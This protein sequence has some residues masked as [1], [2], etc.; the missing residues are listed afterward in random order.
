MEEFQIRIEKEN[1]L[2]ARPAGKLVNVAGGFDSNITVTK[3]NQSASA[4]GL[5]ALMGLGIKQGDKVTVNCEGVDE[6]DAILAVKEFFENNFLSCKNNNK[7]INDDSESDNEINNDVRKE[8]T[9]QT[10]QNIEEN[11]IDN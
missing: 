1:G 6:E 11:F 5:F 3:G 2:H 8:I 4:K 9:E 10:S 7:V